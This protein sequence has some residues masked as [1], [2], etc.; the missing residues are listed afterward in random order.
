MTASGASESGVESD[1]TT[2][3]LPGGE[4]QHGVHESLYSP[5]TPSPPPPPP[6]PQSSSLRQTMTPSPDRKRVR[7]SPVVEEFTVGHT[8]Q[9]SAGSGSSWASSSPPTSWSGPN[10]PPLY[11]PAETTPPTPLISQPIPLPDDEDEDD[12]EH[13][14]NGGATEP[15]INACL[16]VMQLDLSLPSRTFRSELGPHQALLDTAACDPPADVLFLRVD[17]G[18]VKAKIEVR[19]HAGSGAAVTVGDVLSTLHAELRRPDGGGTPADA[20]PYAQQRIAAEGGG[21]ARIVDHLLGRT[22]L[23]GLHRQ[24]GHGDNH[25]QVDLV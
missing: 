9:S 17:T 21:G 14:A 6:P 22:V 2:T 5:R 8:R 15:T 20:V 3:Q 13:E 16:S 23:A 7:W 10:P 19:S 12:G 11:K 25:W 18:L 24:V 4:L 1:T